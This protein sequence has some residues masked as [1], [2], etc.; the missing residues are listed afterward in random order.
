LVQVSSKSKYK[1]KCSRMLSNCRDLFFVLD[2][3]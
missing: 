2:S 3:I 1:C